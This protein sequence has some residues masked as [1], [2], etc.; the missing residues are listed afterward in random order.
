MLPWFGFPNDW[1]M[2]IIP[3]ADLPKIPQNAVVLFG[4]AGDEE[5]HDDGSGGVDLTAPRNFFRLYLTPQLNDYLVVPADAII[6]GLGV[7]SAYLI[8]DATLLWVKPDARLQHVH[9][10]SQEVQAGFLSGPIGAMGGGPA[11]PAGMPGMGGG[12]NTV[13]NCGGGNTVLNCGGGN[14]VLNCG[15]GNTVLNCGGGVSFACG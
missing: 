12:G 3:E 8:L 1:V 7:T 5:N 15:G 9:V 6:F 10:D 11:Y 14:T 13:L 2:N 4:Y